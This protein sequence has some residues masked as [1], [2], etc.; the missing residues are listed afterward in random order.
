MT[1]K[2]HNTSRYL[3]AIELAVDLYLLVLRSILPSGEAGLSH[4]VG[5]PKVIVFMRGM[6]QVYILILDTSW[7]CTLLDMWFLFPLNIYFT[8]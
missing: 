2:K 1:H 3:P 8:I 5:L 4:P 7:Y 6:T